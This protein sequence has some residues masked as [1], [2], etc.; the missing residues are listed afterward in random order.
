MMHGLMSLVKHRQWHTDGMSKVVT[1]KFQTQTS[2]LTSILLQIPQE[3]DP[4]PEAM[5]RWQHLF[6]KECLCPFCSARSS[7]C[8]RACRGN[9]CSCRKIENAVVFDKWFVHQAHDL[10]EQFH[11]AIVWTTTRT[12]LV[13]LHFSTLDSSLWTI[14]IWRLQ[15]GPH[16]TRTRTRNNRGSQFK[17]PF[18]LCGELHGPNRTISSST[19][20]TTF[21]WIVGDIS[22]S[23][24]RVIDFCSGVN[25]GLA[26]YRSRLEF[27][28]HWWER[29]RISSW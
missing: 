4:V 26:E 12:Q 24:A 21:A 29:T 27:F 11:Q 23:W 25:H 20:S 15:V 6:P 1:K 16:W 14:C 5:R 8:R 13:W 28:R 9:G 2:G 19:T 17:R 18:K 7:T 22:N 3:Q 10:P